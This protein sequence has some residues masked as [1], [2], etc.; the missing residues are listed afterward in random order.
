MDFTAE[1][2][3]HNPSP[4]L[5]AWVESRL[6]DLLQKLQDQS[7]QAVVQ[8]EAIRW[9]DL[10]I[11]KLTLELAHLRRMRFGTKSE[12]LGEASRDLFEESL[13][14]DIAACEAKLAA[15]R[16]AAVTRGVDLRHGADA[17]LAFPLTEATAADVLDRLDK[18]IN[19]WC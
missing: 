18:V 8:S 12:A 15:E 3:A 16:E 13:A 6:G 5:A 7:N 1:L 14:T 2:A 4:E 17:P 10:K 19:D 9:R 11:E